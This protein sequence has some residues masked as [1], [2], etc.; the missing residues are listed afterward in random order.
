MAP[1]LRIIALIA[2]VVGLV[3]GGIAAIFLPWGIALLIGLVVGAPTV[4][5]AL[6]S[7]RGRISLSGNTVRVRR[8]FGER[9][10]DTAD[11]VSVELMVRAARVSQVVVRI[12]DGSTAV[13]VPLAL[14]ANGGGRELDLVALRKLA[15]ALANSELAAAAAIS[16]VLV[17]QLRAEALDAGLEGRPLYRAVRLALDAGRT[18]QT[19][20]TDAE[21]AGLL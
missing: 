10:V 13:T 20:L 6:L 5:S 1:R 9:R 21:V 16:S 17:Q 14:Y 11:A 3:V 12:G 4:I 8:P 19:T 18:P 7:M 15:D 2:A